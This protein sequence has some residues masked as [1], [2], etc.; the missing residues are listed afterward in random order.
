MVGEEPSGA[1]SIGGRRPELLL[2][3]GSAAEVGEA[4]AAAARVGLAVAP[5]GGGTALGSLGPPARPYAGLLT[6]RVTGVVEH[7]ADDLTVTVR[8]GTTAAE[9]AKVL[10]AARQR[11]PVDV[12]RPERATVGGMIATAAA[13]PLRLG[14]GT[15]RDYLLGIAVV[16]ADGRLVH[17]GGRVVKNVAGYDLMKLH[18]GAHGTLGVVVEA[19]FRVK[20][21]PDRFSWVVAGAAAPAVAETVRRSLAAAQV[22][23]AALELLSPALAA[24]APAI[25]GAAPARAPWVLAVGIEGVETEVRWQEERVLERLAAAGAS[26]PVTVAE[27]ASHDFLRHIVDFG[28]AEGRNGNANGDDLLLRGAVLASRLPE[29]VESWHSLA[30]GAILAASA[31]NGVVRLRTAAPTPAMV[32]ALRAAAKAA[33]G[34]A[35][36][37]S[38][39]ASFRGVVDP[40]GVTAHPLATRLKAGLDPG[41]V[42]LPGSYLGL[43]AAPRA[44][45]VMA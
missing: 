34:H 29:L 37:E 31:G 26:N 23:A 1:P 7:A 14:H 5:L 39:P 44:A 18:T 28:G 38:M 11:L 3:P 21:A 6:R 33:G 27:P 22:P 4:V 25:A 13:G 45:V 42:F 35:V 2:A 19:T 32:T 40:W 9:L 16:G 41:S 36:I 15:L 24:A 30:P 12:G 17:A 10:A 20:P 8:A 43:G